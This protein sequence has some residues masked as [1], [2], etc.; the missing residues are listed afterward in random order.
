MKL[1]KGES[2][3]GPS[4]DSVLK[5]IGR[6]GQLLSGYGHALVPVQ[7][8]FNRLAPCLGEGKLQGIGDFLANFLRLFLF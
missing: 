8:D 7:N 4:P 3:K 5:I 2:S 1:V 6:L